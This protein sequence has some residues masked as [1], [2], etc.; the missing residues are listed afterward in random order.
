MNLIIFIALKWLEMH[1]NISGFKESK[2]NLLHHVS[3]FGF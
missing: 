3:I 2:A 1:H